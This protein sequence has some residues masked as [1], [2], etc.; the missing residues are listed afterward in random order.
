[1]EEAQLHKERL[2][3]LA[4][5]RKRQTEIEDKRRQLDDLV[6]QVQHFKSKA[7]RE[8]WLLQGI[9]ESEEEEVRRKQ[10]ERD[11][12]QGKKLEDVIHRLESEIG[13]LESEESQIAAK[14][15]VLRARLKE[16]ERSIEDLHKS[17]NCSDWLVLTLQLCSHR[18]V[19]TGILFNSSHLL[20]VPCLRPEDFGPQPSRIMTRT[21]SHAHGGWTDMDT[22]TFAL[23][24]SDL[25]HTR[26]KCKESFVERTKD[27]ILYSQSLSNYTQS[28]LTNKLKL[29]LQFIRERCVPNLTLHPL[30]SPIPLPLLV[31]HDVDDMSESSLLGFD[32]AVKAEVVLIDEDD[33]KS[34]REKTV[35]DMSIID[36][37]AAR[38]RVGA[39]LSPPADPDANPPPP[40][41][42]TPATGTDKRKRCECC[43]LM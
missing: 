39:P 18:S 34:L 35:T 11:E 25:Q 7:T 21:S 9:G 42:L 17:I 28:S 33:E 26:S 29:Q 19:L 10:L 41:G 40:P 16:T 30:H 37:T 8:R 23:L 6:L 15:Q 31:Y 43:I 14:E 5:K 20:S 38:P 27:E 12:E 36:G 22:H 32:G 3:A 13:T 24:T 4:E 2:Q 1:C